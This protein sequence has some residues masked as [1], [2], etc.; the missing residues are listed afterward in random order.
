M[1]GVPE[2]HGRLLLLAVIVVLANLCGAAQAD[3]YR[4]GQFIF[5]L[6]PALLEVKGAVASII[7]MR[8]SEDLSDFRRWDRQPCY[9]VVNPA[10]NSYS[11]PLAQLLQ[12]LKQ[13][14]DL[15]MP[16]C[17]AANQPGITYFL[18]NRNLDVTVAEAISRFPGATNPKSTFVARGELPQLRCG[19]M[20]AGSSDGSITGAIALVDATAGSSSLDRCLYQL[21]VK[22]LGLSSPEYGLHDNITLKAPPG[23]VKTLLEFDLLSL[24]TLYHADPLAPD[25]SADRANQINRLLT[26]MYLQGDND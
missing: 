1:R 13:R 17:A 23:N 14:V 19:W 25:E 9:R 6:P 7:G 21:T 15:D 4:S 3:T 16:E 22:A 11:V 24:F 26:D 8:F 5:R 20:L 12:M 18:T 2:K 10:S